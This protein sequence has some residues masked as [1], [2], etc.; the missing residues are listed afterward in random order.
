MFKLFFILIVAGQWYLLNTGDEPTI[1]ESR[2][3]CEE[4]GAGVIEMLREEK[5]EIEFTWICEEL[6]RAT[7]IGEGK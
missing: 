5:P 4:V 1:F 3:D 2:A 6:V 7:Y